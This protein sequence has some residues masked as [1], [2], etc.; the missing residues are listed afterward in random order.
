MRRAAPALAC[1][2][3]LAGGP[4]LAEERTLV[5]ISAGE[6]NT[7]DQSKAAAELGL[8]WRGGGHWWVF[9]PI[10]GGMVTHQ[11][12]MHGYVGFTFD[13]PLGAHFA[14]RPS[15]APGLYRQGGGK[16]LGYPLEFRSGLEAGWRFSG[17]T[18]VGL[19]FYHISN[20]SLGD[21]NPGSNS[22]MLV[23]AIPTAKLF[24]R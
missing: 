21:I 5:A 9:H 1:L 17:G 15:F 12:A 22:L 2:A 6:H 23:V 18:R 10:V 8:Q 4:T 3:L 13:L 11:G 14:F 16:D 24:G 7:V 19:E 20:A